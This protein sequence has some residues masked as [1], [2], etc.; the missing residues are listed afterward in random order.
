MCKRQNVDSPA[1]GVL[2][3]VRLD[4][5]L[6]VPMP[7]C[8]FLQPTIERQYETTHCWYAKNAEQS[9]PCTGSFR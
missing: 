8:C 6:I 4:R 3:L 5:I 2:S 7:S 9:S 1:N